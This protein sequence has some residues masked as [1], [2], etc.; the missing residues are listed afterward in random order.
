MLNQ[1]NWAVLFVFV[2]LVSSLAA[3]SAGPVMMPDRDVE[4]SVDEAMIAQDKGMAGLMM[5]SVEW[6]ESEFSSLLTVL[7]EQNGGDANPVEA[8]VAMFED[9]KIYL[10]AHLA[11]DAMGS[12]ALVGSVSVENNQV[13]VD[14]EAAGIGDMSVGGAILGPISAHINQALSDPSLGVAVDVEVGDGVIMVSMMQ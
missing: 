14:L 5:G 10:D 1:R 12:I 2:L 7:L 3:C 4:I 11:D 6:T 8:V 9:G 13:M